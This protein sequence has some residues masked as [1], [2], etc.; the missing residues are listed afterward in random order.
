MKQV[1]RVLAY[2]VAAGVVAQAMV[3]V[4]AVGSL[5][6]WVDG[7]GVYDSTVA[8]D[9]AVFPGAGAFRIHE[10][11]GA[12][13]VPGLVVLLGLASLAAR[14]RRGRFVAAI[15]FVLVAAQALLGYEASDQP[16]IGSLHGLFAFGL[17]GV[18]MYAGRLA[19]PGHA[20]RAERDVERVTRAPAQT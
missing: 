6:K 1:Y 12:Y 5:N 13:V 7:G 20:A 3:I 17:F 15:M 8:D 19:S 10:T 11:V 18:A 9:G 14:V 2:A 16:A 4:Y